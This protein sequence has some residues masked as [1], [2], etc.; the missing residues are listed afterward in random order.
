MPQDDIIKLCSSTDRLVVVDEAYID[1]TEEKSSIALLEKFDNLVVLQTFSKALG[2]AGI[3]IGMAYASQELVAVLNAVRM[4]Y[5][6]S[7]SSQDSALT[8]LIDKSNHL[9]RV[10]EIKEQKILLAEKL[11]SLSIV[12]EVIP[13]EANFLLTRFK[14]SDEVLSA[15]RASGIIVRDR[16]QNFMCENCLRISI[17]TPDENILLMQALN[18]ISTK[19]ILST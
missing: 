1:F 19:E 18:K 17:G 9:A 11:S 16:S 7:Q 10:S 3:R 2:G 8:L 14:N 5:N 15:L 6:I 4:P 13:S 12:E